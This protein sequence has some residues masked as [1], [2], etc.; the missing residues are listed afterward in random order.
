MEETDDDEKIQTRKLKDSPVSKGKHMIA[1]S[2]TSE[3][4]SHEPKD[5]KAN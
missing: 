5:D 1:L 3:G 4:K 2:M